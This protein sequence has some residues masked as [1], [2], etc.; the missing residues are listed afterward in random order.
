MDKVIIDLRDQFRDKSVNVVLRISDAFEIGLA[1]L[2]GDVGPWSAVSRN[3]TVKWTM[4]A[5]ADED[6]DAAPSTEQVDRDPLHLE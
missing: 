5:F 2:G 6:E 1:I 3:G 4:D